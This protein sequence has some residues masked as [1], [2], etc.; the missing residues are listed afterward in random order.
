MFIL[1]IGYNDRV[2]NLTMSQVSSHINLEVDILWLT[3]FTFPICMSM[4]GFFFYHGILVCKQAILLNELNPTSE[5]ENASH[6]VGA[7][8]LENI[9]FNRWYFSRKPVLHFNSYL[10][11]NPSMHV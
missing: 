7:Q 2:S 1:K 5:N 4:C 10:A 8:M 3:G 9:I 6:I 11:M